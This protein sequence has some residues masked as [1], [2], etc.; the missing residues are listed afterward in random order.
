MLL[1]ELCHYLFLTQNLPIGFILHLQ[2]GCKVKQEAIEEPLGDVNILPAHIAE[3]H[4]ALKIG[5][6]ST[7]F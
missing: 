6:S 3:L 1:S 5:L 7:N 2:L 4:R